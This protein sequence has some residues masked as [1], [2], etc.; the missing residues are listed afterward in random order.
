MRCRE[1][2]EKERDL[3]KLKNLYNELGRYGMNMNHVIALKFT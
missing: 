3:A 1:R 2:D